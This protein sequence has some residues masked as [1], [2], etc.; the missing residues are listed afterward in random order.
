MRAQRVRERDLVEQVDV[1][2][3][4]LVRE[5]LVARVDPRHDADDVVPTP[6]QRLREIGAVLPAD[7][8]DQGF[9]RTSPGRG[10]GARNAAR[11]FASNSG[12]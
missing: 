4:D 10:V 11:S 3:L 7:S 12:A 1:E 2:Q 6:E 9:H 5:V 8:G